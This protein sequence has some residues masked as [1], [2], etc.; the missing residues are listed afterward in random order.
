MHEL[1]V[2]LSCLEGGPYRTTLCVFWPGV[3]LG[4]VGKVGSFVNNL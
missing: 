3:R 2:K 4:Y 1:D